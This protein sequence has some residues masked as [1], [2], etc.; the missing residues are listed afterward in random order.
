MDVR[1]FLGFCESKREDKARI[2][3]S[4][5]RKHE[6][7]REANFIKWISKTGCFVSFIQ[8]GVR[9]GFK[10]FNLPGMRLRGLIM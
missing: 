4:S 7:F 5:F 8:F 10:Y 9:S 2:K 3:L 6:Y 1:L